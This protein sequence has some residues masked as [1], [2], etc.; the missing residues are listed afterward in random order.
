MFRDGSMTSNRNIAHCR[1]VAKTYLPRDIAKLR[2]KTDG[3]AS[4][5]CLICMVILMR[6]KEKLK[7]ICL[8]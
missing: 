7:H 5:D 2:H 3:M 4:D 6:V 1:S 8:R